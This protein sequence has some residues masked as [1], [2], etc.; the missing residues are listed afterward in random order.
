MLK[1]QF[2]EQFLGQIVSL[3]RTRFFPENWPVSYD[4]ESYGDFGKNTQIFLRNL[5]TSIIL[6][7]H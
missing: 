2:L 7:I 4:T 6:E 5:K 1:F 3:A